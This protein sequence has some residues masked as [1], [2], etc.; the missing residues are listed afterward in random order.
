MNATWYLYLYSCMPQVS[1]V[2]FAIVVSPVVQVAITATCAVYV[3]SGF[4]IAPSHTLIL[5]SFS[6]TWVSLQQQQFLDTDSISCIDR[7]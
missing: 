6:A 4:P 3:V 7:Y 1:H 5:H 2:A